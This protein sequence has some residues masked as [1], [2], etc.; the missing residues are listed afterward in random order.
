MGILQGRLNH[1]SD[2]VPQ[3]AVEIL[4]HGDGAVRLPSGTF[5]DAPVLSGA[6]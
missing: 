1:R 3:I 6:G 2:Q 5:N 4:E